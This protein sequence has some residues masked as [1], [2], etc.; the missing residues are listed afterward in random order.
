M[1]TGREAVIDILYVF[2]NCCLYYSGLQISA[3]PS[4]PYTY[5]TK[6]RGCKHL[7]NPNLVPRGILHLAFI[8]VC[9]LPNYPP[10][11]ASWSPFMEKDPKTQRENHLPKTT[12][13]VL[14]RLG[15]KPW[16]FFSAHSLLPLNHMDSRK[17]KAAV[18]QGH[19]RPGSRRKKRRKG[20]GLVTTFLCRTWQV[21]WSAGKGIQRIIHFL[22]W[23]PLQLQRFLELTPQLWLPNTMAALSGKMAVLLKL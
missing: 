20:S 3:Y 9:I 21:P 19:A 13:P 4:I 6:E 8:T 12:S 18:F 1:W 14:P 22:R 10:K 16:S 7:G 17:Q 11:K 15:F 2:G 5:Q 23:P